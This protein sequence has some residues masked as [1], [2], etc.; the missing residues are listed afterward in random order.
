MSIRKFIWNDFPAL[1][2]AIG[3]PIV[4]IIYLA[5]PF[6]EKGNE[7]L[8]TALPIAATVMF[9][10]ILIWRFRRLARLFSNG[11][12][13]RGQITRISIFRD[14]GRLEFVF[15]YNGSTVASWM[16]VHKSRAVAA[17]TPGDAV[18][19]LFDPADPRRAIVRQIFKA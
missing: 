10:G 12:H 3:I 1:G 18:D 8:P 4:W 11:R 15:D 5:F 9:L 14:R 13:A 7:P 16:P 19:I 2:V 17:L 6:I